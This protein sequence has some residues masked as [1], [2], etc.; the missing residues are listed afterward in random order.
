[1]FYK[2]M[3]LYSVANIILQYIDHLYTDGM[4]IIVKWLLL[5]SLFSKICVLQRR[6][7]LHT[8]LF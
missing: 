3:I 2:G 7:T 5:K 1:M 8:H 6:H 4:K